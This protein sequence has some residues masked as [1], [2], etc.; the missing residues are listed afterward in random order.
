MEI[1]LAE[2]IVEAGD[3]EITL[4]ERYSGR[5]MYGRETAA[6]IAPSMAFIL[7][8]VIERADLFVDEDGEPLFGDFTINGFR[9]DNMGLDMVFY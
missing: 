5:Y 6:V 9:S 2:K 3:G 1:E 8:A 7:Q 4:R